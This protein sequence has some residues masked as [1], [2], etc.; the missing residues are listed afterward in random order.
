MYV[1]PLRLNIYLY[2][3]FVVQNVI[4]Q[5]SSGLKLQVKQQF[6]FFKVTEFQTVN[7]LLLKD[8]FRN[9]Y[10]Y[11]LCTQLCHSRMIY[12][13]F[14]CCQL[15]IINPQQ[16]LSLQDQSCRRMEGRFCGHLTYMLDRLACNTAL[17][18]WTSMQTEFLSA[19]TCKSCIKKNNS[20]LS[21]F[22]GC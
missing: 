4:K 17:Q 13:V 10:L 19:P 15:K 21:H 2:I 5:S 22:S 18:S 16:N 6:I 8:H 11:T 12:P 9:M 20:F 3:T 14:Q 7:L 1:L